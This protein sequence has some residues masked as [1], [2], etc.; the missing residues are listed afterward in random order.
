MCLYIAHLL[1]IIL[2]CLNILVFS[3]SFSYFLFVIQ[4]LILKFILQIQKMHRLDFFNFVF[5]WTG[6]RK[7]VIRK[8]RQ[9]AAWINV[10]SVSEII[11]EKFHRTWSFI[12][13]TSGCFLMAT[14]HAEIRHAHMRN[15]QVTADSN[16]TR[17]LHRWTLGN[18]ESLCKYPAIKK[19]WK[20][21]MAIFFF[22]G[23]RGWKT[24]CP[25]HFASW[26]NRKNDRKQTRI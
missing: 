4:L 2:I 12:I 3:W 11:V 22:K 17:E 5:L 7:E 18:W 9:P 19:D 13:L 15:V 1:C 20:L 23:K 24:V 10:Y 16:A 26:N 14:C 21:I 8:N 25:L 6:T